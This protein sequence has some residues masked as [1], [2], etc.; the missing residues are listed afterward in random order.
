ME[1]IALILSAGMDTVLD[2][3]P[4][5]GLVLFFQIVVLRRRPANLGRITVG[6]LYVVIGLVLFLIG[7]EEALFPLGKTMAAQLTDPAFL[8]LAAGALRALARLWLGLRLRR[9]HRLRHDHRGALAHGR[10]PQGRRRLGRDDQA[11]GPAHRGRHRRRGRRR[12]RGRPHRHRAAAPLSVHVRLRDRHRADDLRLTQHHRARLRFRRRHVV[13]RDRA[14]G[15]STR[16]RPCPPTCPAEARCSTAS[17]SSRLPASLPSSRCWVMPSS[18]RR[19]KPRASADHPGKE[20]RQC[21]SSSSWRSWMP[22][23]RKPSSTPVAAAVRP[24]L[25]SS[26]DAAARGWSRRRPFSA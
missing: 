13:D 14:A 9:G 16:P 23:R 22:A 24:G 11:L 5:I 17:A 7:L 1:L 2:V 21:V 6:F 4:L 15:R 20:L 12:A 3:A 8:G 10:R 19:S 26:R 25:P 18:H